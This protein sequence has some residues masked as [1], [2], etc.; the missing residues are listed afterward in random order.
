MLSIR[1]IKLKETEPERSL[2][3]IV[4]FFKN[5]DIAED[6]K[7]SRSSVYRLLHYK[8]ISNSSKPKDIVTFRFDLGGLFRSFLIETIDLL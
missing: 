1:I 4:N 3:S 7:L 5:Q 8:G 6:F 2:D